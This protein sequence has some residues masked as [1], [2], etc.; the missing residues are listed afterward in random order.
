MSIH[1][2]GSMQISRTRTDPGLIVPKIVNPFLR[3]N[4]NLKPRP[5]GFLRAGPTIRIPWFGTFPV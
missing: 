3:R 5:M 2:L 4:A 1:L